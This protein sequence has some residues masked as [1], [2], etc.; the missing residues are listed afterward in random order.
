MSVSGGRPARPT[1][2][3]TPATPPQFSASLE[4]GD[5]IGTD[6]A[7]GDDIFEHGGCAV[8]FFDRALVDA[9]ADGWTLDGVRAFEEGALPSW[10]RSGPAA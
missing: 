2:S 9:H 5:P 10:A 3:G 1:P 4:P 7:R 6:T 8:H